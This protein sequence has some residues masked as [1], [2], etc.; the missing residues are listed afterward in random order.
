VLVNTADTGK[1]DPVAGDYRRFV[2]GNLPAG[3]IGCRDAC[4]LEAPAAEYPGTAPSDPQ[5]LAAPKTYIALVAGCEPSRETAFSILRQAG[6]VWLRISGFDGS[7]S[8]RCR[9]LFPA[10]FR[11]V[12]P[13]GR[14]EQAVNGDVTVTK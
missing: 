10:R 8:S 13:R 14:E 7:S 12:D 6:R 2:V 11:R 3:W 1:F 9:I 5:L 4:A